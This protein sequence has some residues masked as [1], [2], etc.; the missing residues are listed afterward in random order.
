MR[1]FALSISLAENKRWVTSKLCKRK[2]AK[3]WLFNGF[4]RKLSSKK[5]NCSPTST[6]N[7]C[8][9]Q[10]KNPIKKYVAVIQPWL[11]FKQTVFWVEADPD[12]SLQQR[13]ADLSKTE[14]IHSPRLLLPG[15]ATTAA[16]LTT[17]L[18]KLCAFWDISCSNS[19]Q[20][21]QDKG[22][23]CSDDLATRWSPNFKLLCIPQICVH[24]PT[25]TSAL[26]V[27]VVRINCNLDEVHIHSCL[28]GRKE[29]ISD[30]SHAG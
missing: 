13:Q 2:E 11:E 27:Y 22:L 21:S 3:G 28:E 24:T 8:P 6:N 26:C 9:Q 5:E 29:K 17:K 15:V 20:E 10:L 30:P 12:G 16:I 23:L 7:V 4:Q 25:P 19:M 18:D 14:V 1:M